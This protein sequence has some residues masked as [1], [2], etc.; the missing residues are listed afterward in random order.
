MFDD[1]LAAAL[2][3]RQALADL[4]A[5][6]EQ[7]SRVAGC[8]KL[9]VAAAWA[10]GLERYRV[11]IDGTFTPSGV[12]GTLSIRSVLRSP[13]GRVLERCRTGRVTFAALL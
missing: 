2:G 13:S 9:V 1:E 11:K 3:D 6:V 7:D 12:Q 5:G 8:R 4:A 10:E